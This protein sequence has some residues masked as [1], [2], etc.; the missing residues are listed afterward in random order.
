MRPEVGDSLRSCADCGGF[1]YGGAPNCAHCAAL[2]DEILEAQWRRFYAE[3]GWSDEAELAQLVALEP[4]KY[5][6]R[7]LDA[8]LD[9][10]GCT[11]CGGR[12]SRGPM[13]CA[14]CNL[15]HGYR[16]VAIEVDRPRVPPGNEHAIRVNVSV[17]RRPQMTSAQE[18]LGRRLSLPGLLVG[19][20]PTLAHAQAASARLK[21]GASAAEF[22]A[23]LYQWNQG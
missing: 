21:Q 20:L 9:R 17:V 16:Y 1:E 4:D 8:A 10:I 23:E 19:F 2:V 22:L 12:L 3:T 15:A 6:W 18:L 7:V 11:E 13:D 14:A 5:D